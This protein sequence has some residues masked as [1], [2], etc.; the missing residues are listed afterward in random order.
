MTPFDLASQPHVLIFFDD[1]DLASKIAEYLDKLLPMQYRD[2]GVVQH[3]HSGMSETY[4]QCAH[5]AFTEQDGICKVLCATS[6]ESVM[7]DLYL[8]ILSLLFT[9]WP[10]QGVDFPDV[11]IVC[12]A[13]LPGNVIDSLQRGGCVGQC[14]GDQGLFVIFYE[15]WVTSIPLEQCESSCD[16]PDWPQRTLKPTS[17]ARDHASLASVKLMQHKDCC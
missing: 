3:Y 8:T 9:E 16:D 13:G 5:L 14:D 11:K 1:T 10:I 17:S 2:Q 4:L 6:G 12:N 15:P 7:S